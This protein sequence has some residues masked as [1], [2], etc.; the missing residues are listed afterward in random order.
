M[1]SKSDNNLRYPPLPPLPLSPINL[2]QAVEVIEG[3]IERG[4]AHYVCVCPVSTVLACQ[5]DPAV[6][7][8]VSGAGLVTPDGMPLVWLLR[9]AGHPHVSR[10]YGPDLLLAFCERA[11][12]KGYRSYFYGGADGVAE[13]MAVNLQRRFPNLQVAGWHSPPF[14]PLTAEEDAAVVEMI[15]ASHAD[16]VWVG[17]G[18]PKQDLWMAEHVGRV[19]ATVLVGVGA[20]FDFLSGR[21]RQAPRWMQ[22]SGLEWLFRLSQEPRRLWRRYLLGNPRFV[23]L[24]LREWLSVGQGERQNVK[25]KT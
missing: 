1:V 23:W 17:L 22:R 6:R 14:R 20:A 8:A 16:V 21:V 18:S 2:P 7:R 5:D 24:V 10:V 9:L 25:R 13:Q 3:W 4:E 19:R 12:E 11:V 15:N